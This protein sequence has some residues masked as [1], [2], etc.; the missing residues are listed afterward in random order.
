M[1]KSLR[2]VQGQLEAYNQ[3]DIDGFMQWYRED[4]R[5]Y[6]LDEEVCLFEGHEAMRVRYAKLFENKGLHCILKNRM[7]L[8]HSI[9]DHEQIARDT[10]GPFF[11]AIAIYDVHMDGKI[12]TIR[13]TKGKL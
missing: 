9:I 3:R 6:D 4:V 11:E 8:G 1:D 5:A 12:Q 13:F 7:V 10:E 2:A